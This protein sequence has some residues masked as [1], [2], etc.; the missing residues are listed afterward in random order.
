MYQAGLEGILGIARR[1]DRL[2][3]DPCLPTG[4]PSCSVVWTHGPTV[5]EITIENP[6]AQS[7]G[8]AF[9]ELDGRTVDPEAIPWRDDG[10]H[11]HVRVVLGTAT[12]TDAPVRVGAAS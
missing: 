11:H 4:W 3:V 5:F 1:G 6:A 2:V 10:G 9:A 7:R 12:D 8:V